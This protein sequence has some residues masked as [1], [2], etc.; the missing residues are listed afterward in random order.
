MFAIKLYT[1][2]ENENLTLNI[3]KYVKS[4]DPITIPI[5]IKF[6]NVVLGSLLTKKRSI[7]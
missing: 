6:A 1:I 2:T 4:I 7:V 3:D 5:A